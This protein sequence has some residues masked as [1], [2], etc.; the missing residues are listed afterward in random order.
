VQLG[1]CQSLLAPCGVLQ[2]VAVLYCAIVCCSVCCSMLQYVAVLY[3]ATVCCS[4]V[5]CYSMLQCML[6]YVAVC[7]TV[8]CSVVLCYSM[9]QCCIVL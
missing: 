7:C 8:C 4:V 6:Q 1:L 5:L 9:L 2:Y 3:C